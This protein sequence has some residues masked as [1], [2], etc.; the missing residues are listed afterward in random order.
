M[1]DSPGI[2][3]VQY[4]NCFPGTLREGGA[5]FVTTNW[6]VVG[7]CASDGKEAEASLT[8]LCR[9]YWPPLYSFVRRRGYSPADAQDLVQGFFAA[10]L[11]TKAYA[12]TDRSMGKFRS[13]MLASLKHYL[14]NAWDRE[15]ALKRGGGREFVLLEPQMEAA[16]NLYASGLDNPTLDEEQHYEERWAETLVACALARLETE[17]GDGLKVRIFRELKPFLCGGVDLPNQEDIARRL[18]MPINT[19]RSHL[20]RLRARYAQILHE[21][22]A[23]TIGKRD[24]VDEELRHFRRI[25]MER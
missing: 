11:K 22:V 5:P 23:R 6:S 17:F 4:V 20:S 18:K 3:N 13:F 1:Q 9:D 25:L 12:K 10:F 15:R 2:Y 8:Q 14:A 16:E 7:D 24:D 21:E 19:L